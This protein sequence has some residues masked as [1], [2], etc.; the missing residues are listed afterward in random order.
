MSL[1]TIEPVG[2]AD[3]LAW[4]WVNEKIYWTDYC[5]D[6]IEVYDPQ[7]GSRTVLFNT[8]L[9]EPHAIVVDPTTQ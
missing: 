1:Q 2:N 5:Q 7:S 4:D 6:E 9:I 3:G 8:D